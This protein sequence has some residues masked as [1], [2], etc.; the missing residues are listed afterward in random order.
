MPER[1]A[2]LIE[3]VASL[4][5][6]ERFR[7]FVHSALSEPYDETMVDRIVAHRLEESQALE[8][9]HAQAAA[10]LGF[11]VAG[12]LG[13]IRAPT[14][15]VTG[16]A[17][18]VVDARNSDLLLAGIGGA[19]LERFEGCGHLFFW[20][21]PERFVRLVTEFLSRRLDGGDQGA[22]VAALPTPERE[23]G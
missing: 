11:D 4:P 19:R 3:A 6:E 14:L 20:Q 21:E 23:L 12:R 15:V 9:W 13:E 17:D 8:A 1:T 2:G 5:R 16:T 10:A 18:E 7:R 22:E